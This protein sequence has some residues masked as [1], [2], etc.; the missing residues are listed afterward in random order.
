MGLIRPT[1]STVLYFVLGN[2]IMEIIICNNCKGTGSTLIKIDK[3]WKSETKCK[4][5]NGSGRLIKKTIYIPIVKYLNGVQEF[6]HPRYDDFDEEKYHEKP[7]NG[8][9]ER[10]KKHI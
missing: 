2:V 1:Q 8:E 3:Y 6:P 9:T 4:K 5:C 10:R 7:W